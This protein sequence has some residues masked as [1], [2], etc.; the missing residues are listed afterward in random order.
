MLV[1]PTGTNT[2]LMAGD[3]GADNVS[4]LNLTF[5]DTGAA[6]PNPAPASGTFT[7]RPTAAFSPA[8]PASTN[9][10]GLLPAPFG[11]TLSGFTNSNPN[12]A[13]LLYVVDDVVLNSGVIENGWS[14][15][16]TSLGVLSPTVDL[17]AG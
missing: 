8:F 17:V 6:F 16:I 1:G 14:L 3:G 10:P 15:T 2:L 4:G 5:D 7:Y 9:G 12:G 11:A 13:W